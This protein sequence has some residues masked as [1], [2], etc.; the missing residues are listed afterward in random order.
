MSGVHVAVLASHNGSNLRALHRT[1]L[2]PDSPFTIS[3]VIS[4]N[5]GSGALAFARDAG[6]PALHLSGS[7]HPEPELLDAAIRSALTAHETDLV[8]TAGYMKKLGPRTRAEYTSRIVNVHPALLPRHGGK[9]M[10]GNAVHEAVLASG[11]TVS[12]PTVHLVTEDY[13]AG[14]VLAQA[15]VPVVPGDT[16][17][18]LAER[19]LVAEHDLLPAVVRRLAASMSHTPTP[20]RRP[21]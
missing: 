14:P 21:W 3:L 15:R 17:E 20:H 2:S 9:G 7:T 18:S 10:Y 4:N 6:I 8:V 13:D 1:S 19:V 12:G 11:D 5:S 16:A